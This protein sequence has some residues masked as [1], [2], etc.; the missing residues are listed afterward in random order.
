LSDT[1]CAIGGGVEHTCSPEYVESGDLIW[2][3]GEVPGGWLVEA[4]PD[5]GVRD[6]IARIALG[7]VEYPIR[8][9][10]GNPPAGECMYRLAPS[11]DVHCRLR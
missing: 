7:G 8:P 5:G 9:Q 6:R 10:R 1:V 11:N 3:N 2:L 4:T